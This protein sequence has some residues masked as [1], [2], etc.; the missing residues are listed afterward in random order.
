[1]GQPPLDETELATML[2]DKA[3]DTLCTD[4]QFGA[5]F[6]GLAT[7]LD[8][9]KTLVK[10]EVDAAQRN[11]PVLT[12]IVRAELY[13]MR[14][15]IAVASALLA[16]QATPWPAKGAIDGA[17]IPGS[18]AWI[19]DKLVR[20]THMI[21]TMMTAAT[22]TFK[23]AFIPAPIVDTPLE[24][25]IHEKTKS[26]TTVTAAFEGMPWYDQLHLYDNDMYCFYTPPHCR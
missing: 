11:S 2:D 18:V 19:L 13:R 4:P 23:P 10:S 15:E 1:M 14:D 12:G 24:M 9:L 7:N 26:P 3:I 8:Q 20:E 5:Q 17:P 6:F 22:F 21:K 25:E 16:L